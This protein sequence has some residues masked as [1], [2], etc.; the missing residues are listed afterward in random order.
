MWRALQTR[1][2]NTLQVL[3]IQG[4]GYGLVVDAAATLL[5]RGGQ[6]RFYDDVKLVWHDGAIAGYRSFMVTLPA[7]RFGYLALVNGD[8]DHPLVD[9][10]PAC[11]RVAAAET[12]SDRLPPPSPFPAPD[13][14]RDRFSDYIGDYGDR[15]E[16]AGRAV[17]TLTPAGDLHV[18]FPDLDAVG[19]L[20]DPILQPIRRDNFLL[21]TQIGSLLFTG[22]RGSANH[23]EHLRTRLTV[24]SRSSNEPSTLRSAPSIDRRALERA[25]RAAARERNPVGDLPQ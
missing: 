4:Y 20:Y 11:F 6:Q 25:I 18:Q 12:I 22:I 23:I 24:L 16:V 13:I 1:Q 3:D 15:I 2:V 10:A 17:V 7:Q 5:D 14:Q 19:F 9:L 21:H 8:V